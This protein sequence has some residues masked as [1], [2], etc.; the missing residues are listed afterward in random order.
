MLDG[1]AA[2]TNGAGGGIDLMWVI[3]PFI[4]LMAVMMFFGYRRNKKE[5]QEYVQ[6]RDSLM[7]GDEVTTIGGIIGKVVS[8]K[9]ETFVLETTKDRTKI[10]FHKGSIKRIDV[11][12]ADIAQENEKAT[13]KADEAPEAKTEDAP[14]LQVEDGSVAEERAAKAEAKARKAA[15]K[16]EAK[17]AKEAA[18]A[19]A[20]AK[21]EADGK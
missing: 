3:V 15:A 5:E 1:A 19:E 18:K 2:G 8:I 6:M 14:I 17:A 10:R 9:E 13:A 20:K 21:E 4:I 16:A 12:I 11:K 7:V